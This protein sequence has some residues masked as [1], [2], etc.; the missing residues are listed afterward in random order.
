MKGVLCRPTKIFAA[1]SLGRGQIQHGPFMGAKT[2]PMNT[3]QQATPQLS[4]LPTDTRND[5]HARR[6]HWLPRLHIRC[7]DYQN[8]IRREGLDD[9]YVAP[10]AFRATT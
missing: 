2:K 4:F 1:S 9:C 7:G 8:L 6:P 3:T 5:L 10:T